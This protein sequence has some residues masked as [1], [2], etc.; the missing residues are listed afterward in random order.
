[1]K[2]VA[3]VIGLLL[4]PAV[5]L[6]AEPALQLTIGEPADGG[7]ALKLILLMTMVT[8]APAALLTMTSFVRIVVVLSFLKNA[9]GVQSAPPQQ[10]MIGLALFLTI[11]VMAPVGER[12][13]ANG[14]APYLDGKQGFAESVRASVPPV[15]SFLLAQTRELDLELFYELGDL[16]SPDGPEDVAMH[17]L[18]PAFVISE[19]RTAFEMGFMLFLPFLLLDLV[20]ASVL[21]S[22]GM[23]M[24]PPALVSL[25]IKIM[26]FVAADGWRLIAGS[27]VRSF[28]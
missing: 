17:L 13:Y 15:R 28:S 12:V 26:L 21:M 22:M 8:L 18:V 25:P 27:L 11:A 20:V 6:A 9:L 10:V 2:P 14:L 7:A 24:L 5:S 3:I 23:V 16:P 4:T 19:L 1:M